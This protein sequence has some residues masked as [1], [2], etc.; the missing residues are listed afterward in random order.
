MKEYH[1][2]IQTEQHFDTVFGHQHFK[3]PE[4]QGEVSG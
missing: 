3:L 1:P 2:K 4:I